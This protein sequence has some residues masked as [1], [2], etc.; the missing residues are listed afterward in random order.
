LISQPVTPPVA[1]ESVSRRVF[2]YELDSA[3]YAQQSERAIAIE[4]I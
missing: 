2:Q 4:T 1:C 3:A